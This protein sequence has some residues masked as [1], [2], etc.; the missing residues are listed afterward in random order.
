MH[1]GLVTHFR[2]ALVS[3]ML[4][5][6][7]R[8]LAAALGG[9]CNS[10]VVNLIPALLRRGHQVSIFA[11]ET[12]VS[13]PVKL[14]GP[15]LTVHMVPHRAAVL[16]AMLD[17]YRCERRSL[18]LAVGN[19]NPDVVHGQ[20]THTGHALAALDT[21][22]PCVVTAH[23]AALTCAW[24]G[25]G[26][27]PQSILTQIAVL[28]MT[29]MVV[30][31]CRSMVAVSP[32]VARHLQRVFRYRGELRVIPNAISVETVRPCR[33]LRKCAPDPQHPVFGDVASWGCLKNIKSLL[34]G[35]AILRHSIPGARLVLFGWDLGPG[36]PAESWARGMKLHEQ[37]EFRDWLDYSEL[38]KCLAAEIDIL[39]H[40]S[41]CEANSMVLGEA[42]CLG[43]PVITGDVGGNRW[44]LGSAAGGSLVSNVLDPIEIADKMAE[45]VNW[46]C[47]S[48]CRPD[49][50]EADLS[51]FA[52][53]V[54][55]AQLESVYAAA[56]RSH[57]A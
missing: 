55:A 40:P 13:K 22:L 25:L 28:A 56:I 23:D 30:R 4:D 21:G 29:W 5:E 6:P 7:S 10:P 37:V 36:G 45:K 26:L 8:N 11:A 24:F 52:P 44:S 51:R 27:W 41:R 54:V 15:G 2:P 18:V 57:R 47:S 38:L 9:R 39:V 42:L 32:Y 31:H 12:G 49:A 48:Q 17:G 33:E 16:H 50:N 35:F 46:V 34:R 1:I 3:P 43:I 53:E 20:W 19:A 14:T